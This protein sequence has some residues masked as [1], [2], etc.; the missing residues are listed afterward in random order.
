M[1]ATVIVDYMIVVIAGHD[2]M[3]III[4]II[5]VIILTTMATVMISVKSIEIY[6]INTRDIVIINYDIVNS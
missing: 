6:I 2:G 3:M 4:L 5:V 1:G